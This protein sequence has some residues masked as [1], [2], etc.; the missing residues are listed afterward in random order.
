MTRRLSLCSTVVLALSLAAVSF[1]QAPTPKGP[2][3]DSP[4]IEQRIDAML[5]KLTTDEKIQ[6]IGGTEN[7]YTFPAPALVCRS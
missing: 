3:P 5:A 4:A 6:L 7:F 1:A 2:I